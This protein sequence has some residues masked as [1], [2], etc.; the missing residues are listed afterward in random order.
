MHGWPGDSGGTAGRLPL[1][2]PP[3]AV[4][5]HPGKPWGTRGFPSCP[6]DTVLLMLHIKKTHFCRF[7]QTS[8]SWLCVTGLL[9]A[10][11]MGTPC[12]S[13]LCRSAL[14]FLPSRSLLPV[15][16]GHVCFNNC[17]SVSS[18]PGAAAAGSRE[19]GPWEGGQRAGGRRAP[20][21]S[22]KE[23]GPRGARGLKLAPLLLPCWRAEVL[24][25]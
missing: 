18:P 3:P 11:A 19:L 8:I 22:P 23:A 1:R 12:G 2:Q 14:S 15:W 16:P 21:P 13:P 20:L 17:C 25:L 7:A 9:P 5:S 10:A 4:L 6:G 24:A